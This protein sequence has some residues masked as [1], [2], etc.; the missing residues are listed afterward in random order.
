MSMQIV[1]DVIVSH[2][3]T[4][5]TGIRYGAL[6]TI[7]SCTLLLRPHGHGFSTA[8]AAVFGDEWQF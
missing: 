5:S 4:Q 2:T 6:R 7:Y 1:H 8:A 3:H